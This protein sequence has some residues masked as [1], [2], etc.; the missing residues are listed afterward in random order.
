METMQMRIDRLRAEKAEIEQIESERSLT[1]D[2]IDRKN[3]LSNQLAEAEHEY[4][5]QMDKDVREQRHVENV[6]GL[7]D[8]LL[9]SGLY[10]RIWGDKPADG[11]R[12]YEYE[13]NRS[14]FYKIF[15]A[16]MEEEKE[17]D[18][19]YYEE[20]LNARD[21]K[22]SRLTQH[23]IETENQL[24]AERD[25]VAELNDKIT[26]LNAEAAEQEELLQK[27]NAD[28]DKAIEQLELEKSK[29]V[30]TTNQ[31]N[32]LGAICEQKTAQ[33]AELETKL[34]KAE[35]AKASTTTES[36]KNLIANLKPATNWEA[37]AN[38]SLERWPEL[39]LP[40]ITEPEAPSVNGGD[41]FR[42]ENT[43]AEFRD[44]QL[45]SPEAPEAVS[46]EQFRLGNPNTGEQAVWGTGL[47][48]AQGS[49]NNTQ[50]M[51]EA[52]NEAAGLTLEQKVDI[53][54]KEREQGNAAKQAA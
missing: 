35:K 1:Q 47:G 10:E 33:I 23:G 6:G 2:E 48:G 8:K 53:L 40:P 46:E 37:K 3:F 13:E 24:A 38:K 22:I 43:S 16:F 17:A 18:R 7:M 34:E 52:A 4:R 36:T 54:W 32:Q 15:N 26:E 50:A 28:R 11:E 42:T 20:L 12:I 27:A 25:T 19:Q 41:S 9:D 49:E 30:L 45:L 39:N 51:D 14:N 5:L 29:H 31:Y 21:E 44:N